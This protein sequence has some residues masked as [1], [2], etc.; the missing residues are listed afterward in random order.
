MVATAV[1]VWLT[2][3][4]GTYVSFPQYRATPP[5][6]MADLARYPRALLLSKADTAWLHGVGMEIKEHVPWIAAMLTTAVAFVAVRYRSI[7]LSDPGLR[8]MA[9]TLLAISFLLLSSVGGLGVLINKVAP[10]Q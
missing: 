7:L 9:F 8:R 10:L 5:E 3:L 2:V 4:V 1:I 6:G